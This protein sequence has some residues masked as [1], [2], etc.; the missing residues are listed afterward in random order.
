MPV[1]EAIMDAIRQ[2]S[3]ADLLDLVRALAVEVESPE[4]HAVTDAGSATEPVEAGR[5]DAVAVSLRDFG[6]E[7]IGIIR[8]VREI[9][10]LGLREALVLA[11][12]SP[13]QVANWDPDTDPDTSTDADGPGTAGVPAKPKTPPPTGEGSEQLPIPRRSRRVA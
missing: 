4:G 9:T 1:Q 8:A 11:G 12:A 13:S 10:D 7:R 2:M 6:A 5:R 3:V